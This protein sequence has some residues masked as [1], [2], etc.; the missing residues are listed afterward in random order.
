M[1]Y[2]AR[3]API[4]YFF[5]QLDCPL[6]LYPSIKPVTIV[7]SVKYPRLKNSIHGI[8]AMDKKKSRRIATVIL[9]LFIILAPILISPFFAVGGYFNQYALVS[10]FVCIGL[11]VVW[12]GIYGQ[13]F[14]NRK[15]DAPKS[16]LTEGNKVGLAGAGIVLLSLFIGVISLYTGRSPLQIGLFVLLLF[17][18]VVL[19]FVGSYMMRKE[20][21][22]ALHQI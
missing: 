14:K 17:I 18:G 4:T 3:L 8:A 5:S 10:V 2:A 13:K 11:V 22:K 9:G 21:E 19:L 20:R 16:Q 6:A 1:A 7:T 12:Q 15:K